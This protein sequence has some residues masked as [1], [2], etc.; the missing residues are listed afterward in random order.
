[1]ET[2]TLKSTYTV[3]SLDK[4]SAWHVKCATHSYA[5]TLFF[6]LMPEATNI[7]KA[8]RNI[9]SYLRRSMLQYARLI[10]TD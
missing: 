3:T 6:P 7:C 10:L 1:M 4:R 2:P 8:S 5:N 9:S